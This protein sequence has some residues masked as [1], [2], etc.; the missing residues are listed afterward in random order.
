MGP[1]KFREMFMEWH[2]KAKE[3]VFK[4]CWL[5]TWADER[6]AVCHVPCFHVWCNNGD[7]RR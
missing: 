6:F 5:S 2:D 3:L 4:S 1:V 7:E